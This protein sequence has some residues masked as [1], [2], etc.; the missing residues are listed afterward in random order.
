MDKELKKL[1]K[2]TKSLQLSLN[3]EIYELVKNDEEELIYELTL[4]FF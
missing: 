1:I 4:V 3:K 2:I